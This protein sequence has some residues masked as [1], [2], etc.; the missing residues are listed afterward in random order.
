MDTVKILFLI[1]IAGHLLCGYCDCL[2]TYIPGGKK[3]DYKQLSDNEKMSEAFE[4]MPLKNPRLS[5]I[6]GC[7]AMF[8]SAG[9]YYGVYLW[10]RQY[11]EV[12][13]LI[14]LISSLLFFIPGVAHHVF[15]GVAEWFYIRLGRTEEARQS[16]VQFF[17]ETSV[18]MYACY[19][20]I[21][22]FGVT[23][24][25]AVVSGATDLPAWACVFNVVPMFLVLMPLRIGGTGNWCSAAMFLVLFLLI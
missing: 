2:I 4:G 22:V 13:A 25:I 17:K 12:Y 21:L 6:L 15:C 18:T 9:G 8:L 19:A 5:M 7:L 10:M 24:F 23:M 14:L 20:G 1:A 11:S 3:F 16:V